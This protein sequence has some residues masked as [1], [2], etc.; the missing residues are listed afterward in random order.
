MTIKEA[1][2]IVK[3][4]GFKIVESYDDYTDDNN[5]D[6]G[7]RTDEEAVLK[8]QWAAEQHEATTAYYAEKEK[9]ARMVSSKGLDKKILI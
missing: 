8:R 7:I 3:N 6:L 5:D 9:Y 2:Q 1:K 4:S